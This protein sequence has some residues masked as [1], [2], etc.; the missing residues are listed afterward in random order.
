MSKTRK[1]AF[2]G[3][4]I[5][6]YVVL[7]MILNFPIVA[8]V[9]FD[10]GYVCYAVYLCLF[11][12]WGIPVGVVGCFIKGYV[13][14]GWIPF[15]WMV[16]QLIVGVSCAVVFSKTKGSKHKSMFRVAAIIISVLIGIGI[17]SSLMSAIMFHQPIMLKIGRGIITAVADIIPM[18]VGLFIAQ[19]FE[20]NQKVTV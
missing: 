5:A 18:I 9:R 12:W 20:D 3:V 13:S 14:D 10:A 2:I 8:H 4:G 17:V 16:G 7:S 15:T 11:G 1:I 6:L 19:R